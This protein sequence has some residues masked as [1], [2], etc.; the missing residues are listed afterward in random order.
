MKSKITLII[1]AFAFALVLGG[2]NSHQEEMTNN[3]EYPRH[4]KEFTTKNG[5]DCILY[6]HRRHDEA[7][8]SCNWE[9]YN[10]SK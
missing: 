5:V 8:M 1:I 6:S 9:K 3:N 10:A 4:I 2:C 7:G